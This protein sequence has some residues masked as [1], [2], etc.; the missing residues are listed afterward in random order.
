MAFYKVT[1]RKLCLDLPCL[2]LSCLVLSC[3]VLSCL[4]LSCHVLFCLVLSGL[5]MSCFVLSCL[6]LS[7]LVLS[8]NNNYDQHTTTM[9]AFLYIKRYIIPYTIFLRYLRTR[10]N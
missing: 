4:V 8:C 1:D 10:G 9:C 3:L 6:V 7:C 5:V 2:V